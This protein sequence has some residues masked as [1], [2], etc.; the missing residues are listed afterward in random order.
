MVNYFVGY[1]YPGVFG[2]TWSKVPACCDVDTVESDT[3][4]FDIEASE[5]NSV[6][7]DQTEDR[8]WV[9]N[10]WWFVT[11]HDKIPDAHEH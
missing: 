11:Q 8:F 5:V 7:L 9:W 1:S 3:G 10:L 6:G 4:G 2:E